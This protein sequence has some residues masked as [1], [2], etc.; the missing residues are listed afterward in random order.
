MIHTVL[1][2]LYGFI[3][4]FKPKPFSPLGVDLLFIPSSPRQEA[5]GPQKRPPQPVPSTAPLRGSSRATPSPPATKT[6]LP[7]L[8]GEPSSREIQTP[9]APGGPSSGTGVVAPGSEGIALGSGG[10]PSGTGAT[11][12]TGGGTPAGTKG[13]A[14]GSGGPSSRTKTGSSGSERDDFSGAE[15]PSYVIDAA[16]FRSRFDDG[17][18]YPE[19]DSYVLYGV[20]KQM[21]IPVPGTEVCVEGDQLHTKER[22]T[23]TEVKTDHSKCRVVELGDLVPLK[24][25]CPP[26][27]HTRIV[28]LNHYASS[29]LVY[30]VR[31][32][33]EYDRSHCYDAVF[34]DTEREV[35]RVDF[36]YE[37]IW[38][39]GTIFDYKCAKSEAR[40]YRHPLQYDIRWIMEV[41][42]P[43][44]DNRLG[45]RQ[46]YQETRTVEPCN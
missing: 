45:K 32:C 22:T 2:C 34:G 10:S 42:I 14:S 8:T 15:I 25:I 41:Y 13:G 21:G 37:G 24:E 1:L 31:T 18:I 9:T 28:H 26:E 3:P 38:A 12:S 23:I 17:G 40:A 7:P 36:R 44:V 46:I 16:G 35:C 43:G 27:A 39:E 11:P 19:I 33:L 30:S 5:S 29:P 6:D 20:D 4:P